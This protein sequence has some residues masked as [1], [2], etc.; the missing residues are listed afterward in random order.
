MVREPDL[1]TGAIT[2]YHCLFKYRRI[3]LRN[4]QTA[5]A[6]T[7]FEGIMPLLV[8]IGCFITAVGVYIKTLCL[9]S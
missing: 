1:K 3:C 4:N 5:P 6:H 7:M 9:G 2:I 8:H